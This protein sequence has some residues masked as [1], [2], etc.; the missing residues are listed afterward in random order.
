MWLRSCLLLCL[1]PAVLWAQ[2]PQ[3]DFESQAFK[4]KDE[5]WVLDIWASWCGPCVQSIPHLKAMHKRLSK[6][7]V[8]IFGLSIDDNEQDWRNALARY[9]M[10]WDHYRY[11][12]N[13]RTSWLNQ[14]IRFS[15]IPTVV[16]IDKTG[17]KKVFN[18]SYSAE[19]YVEKLL[20]RL[21]EKQ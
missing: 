9:Q 13:L 10:P 16:V 14:H 17:K 11:S 6:Q 8:R 4:P 1:L 3:A 21:K 20:I 5:I 7:G 15:A 18:N 2:L 19:A 12:G